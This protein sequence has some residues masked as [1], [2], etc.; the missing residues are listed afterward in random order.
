MKLVPTPDYA[1]IFTLPE[2]R[3][4]VRNNLITPDDGSGHWCYGEQMDQDSSVF[5][6][7]AIPQSAT[8]VAWF[9]K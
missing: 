3:D 2:F 4:A 9:N 1:D 8:G 7:K 5:D 6:S